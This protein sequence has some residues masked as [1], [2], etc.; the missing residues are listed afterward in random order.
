MFNKKTLNKIK[1]QG[2]LIFN[3]RFLSSFSPLQRYEFLRFCHRRKYNEGEYIFYQNDPATGMYFI[4]SGQ[5]RLIVEK[6]AGV[7]ELENDTS[8]TFD[9][10]APESFGALSIGYD[11]RRTSSARSLT[12]CVLLGFF[13]PDFES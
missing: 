7:Q 9:L 1:T 12:D 8:L 11:L 10:T 6:E 2:T 13:K 3:S 4:E 5:V